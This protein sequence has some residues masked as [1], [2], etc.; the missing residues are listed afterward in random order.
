M[1]LNLF[2]VLLAIALSIYTERVLLRLCQAPYLKAAVRWGYINSILMSLAV[3]HPI[4]KGLHTTYVVV[5]GLVFLL[6]ADSIRQR[7]EM[8]DDQR[9]RA[10]HIAEMERRQQEIERIEQERK[11]WRAG[12]CPAGYECPQMGLKNDA[13]LNRSICANFPKPR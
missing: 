2:P 7:A 8:E 5:G 9:R 12:G 6:A 3:F 13:C 4:L 1:M 11:R 10:E